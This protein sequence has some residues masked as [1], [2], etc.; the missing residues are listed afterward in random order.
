MSHLADFKIGKVTHYYDKIKVAVVD[1]SASL[2]V[3]DFVHFSGS[4]D[5]SQAIESMQ[6]EHEQVEAAAKGDTVGVKVSQA[7][8]PGDEVLKAG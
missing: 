2:H 5:F 1:L 4:S 8:K 3:G 6:M 7:V